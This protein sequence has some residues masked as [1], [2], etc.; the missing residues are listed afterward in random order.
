MGASIPIDHDRHP[1]STPRQIKVII[2]NMDTLW[3]PPLQQMRLFSD[4]REQKAL[5]NRKLPRQN[6]VLCHTPALPA[7]KRQFLHFTCKHQ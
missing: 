6:K 7:F 3:S 5:I 2:A 4:Q 1:R